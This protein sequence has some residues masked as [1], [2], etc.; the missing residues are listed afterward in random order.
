MGNRKK[1]DFGDSPAG[2][3]GLDDIELPGSRTASSTTGRGPSGLG[4]DETMRLLLEDDA[5]AFTEDD[6]RGTTRRIQPNPAGLKK[7]YDPYDSGMLVKK[8]W[9]KKKDMRALSD[10]IEKKKK[11]DGKA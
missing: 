3:D 9:K 11:L 8:Q 5:L 2:L 10:W 7:G 4:S 1:T 6:S